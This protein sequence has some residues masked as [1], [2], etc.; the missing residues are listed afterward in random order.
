MTDP[1]A[2]AARPFDKGLQPERTALA[3]R[4]TS[5]ALVVGAIICIRVLPGMLGAWAAIP[6]GAGLLAAIGV[7]VAS[8]RRYDTHHRLLTSAEHD[9]IPLADG[10]MPAFVA[11]MGLGGGILILSAIV[12]SALRG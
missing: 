11:A 12:Y 2:R 4:R 8:H 3:W 5:L 9:R 1:A 7:F 10:L 6:A